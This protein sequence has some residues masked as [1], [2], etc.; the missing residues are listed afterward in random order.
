MKNKK[1]QKIYKAHNTKTIISINS[2]I[3]SMQPGMTVLLNDNDMQPKTITNIA[4]SIDGNVKYCLKWFDGS[5]LKE[6]WM[7]EAEMLAMSVTIETESINNN[8]PIGFGV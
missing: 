7:S 4:I 6:I 3:L 2:K 1:Q 8:N 5:E